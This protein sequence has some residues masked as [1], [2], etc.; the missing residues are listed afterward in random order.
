MCYLLKRGERAGRALLTPGDVYGTGQPPPRRISGN[1]SPTEVLKDEAHLRAEL[2][3]YLAIVC[4]KSP[5]CF[6]CE[7]VALLLPNVGKTLTFLPEIVVTEEEKFRIW[8]AAP[9]WIV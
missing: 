9:T 2:L 6:R 8:S 7:L 3:N 4:M 5:A 1:V